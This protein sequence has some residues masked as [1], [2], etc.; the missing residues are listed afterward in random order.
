MKNSLEEII[1]VET[2]EEKREESSHHQKL[3]NYGNPSLKP[4][5]KGL[6]LALSE[7]EKRSGFDRK[8]LSKNSYL[9]PLSIFIDFQ[10]DNNYINSYIPTWESFSIYD[11][12]GKKINVSK[13]LDNQHLN[14]IMI[15]SKKIDDILKMDFSSRT[16]YWKD[17]DEK[18]K[19]K[20]FYENCFSY[21]STS[22]TIE[23]PFEMHSALNGL[24]IE[25]EP[26]FDYQ[27]FAYGKINSFKI[28]FFDLFDQIKKEENV[29]DVF[30]SSMDYKIPQE[31]KKED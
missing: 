19:L 27:F 29:K 20:Y 23:L 30:L 8:I 12:L 3:V 14:K 16:S 24:N 17:W 5:L 4:K 11:D 26:D 6:L 21:R 31:N 10:V 7:K 1:D 9:I 2:Y 18:N 22:Y 25:F 15:N 13:V 28:I